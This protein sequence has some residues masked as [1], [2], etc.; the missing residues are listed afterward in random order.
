MTL[1]L[2]SATAGL[3]WLVVCLSFVAFLAPLAVDAQ[4]T[5]TKARAAPPAKT[6]L[7]AKATHAAT[8]W[9]PNPA[10]GSKDAYLIIDATSGREL[11]SDQPDEPRHPASLT[12]LMTLYLTFSALDSGRL[13]LGDA[14]PVS[15]SALNAPPTK[16]GMTPGGNVTVRD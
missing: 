6:R 16:M 2:R 1:P 10:A 11:L 8:P 12:K 9:V 15:I 4:N 5:S 7:P 3:R 13:S 14:L